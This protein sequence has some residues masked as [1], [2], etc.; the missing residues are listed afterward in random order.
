MH[1]HADYKCFFF[2]F[3]SLQKKN[4]HSSF[5]RIVDDI[6]C[7]PEDRRQVAE[8]VFSVL[9]Y[10]RLSQIDHP[11]QQQK[12]AWRSVVS[13]QRKRAVIACFRQTSLHS[14]PRFIYILLSLSLSLY[15]SIYLSLSFS[16]CLGIV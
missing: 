3:F 11:Q 5:F 14:L 1:K 9:N 10:A 16:L 4:V 2:F 8:F 7:H 15:L 13:T 12:G 6:N